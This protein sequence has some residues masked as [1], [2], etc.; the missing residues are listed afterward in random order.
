[1]AAAAGGAAVPAPERDLPPPTETETTRTAVFG[2]GCFWCVEAVFEQLD[3]VSDVVSGYAGDTVANANYD[4]VSNGDTRHAEVVRITYDPRKITYAQL[5]Q[6]FFATHDPTTKD[7]QGPDW[8]TQ[9]RSSI[10]FASDAEKAVAE[11]Y[12]AQLNAA[13]VFPRPIVTTIEPIGQ[14]FFPAEKYHQDFARL[15]PSHPY[16]RQWSDAKVEKVRK[17]FPD[18]VKK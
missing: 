11:A 13:K 18:R 12:I 9:Y 10:F 6:V 15:N 1:M 7:R 3:G 2:G 16:I 5:L 14:G 8:G 4:K 17:T